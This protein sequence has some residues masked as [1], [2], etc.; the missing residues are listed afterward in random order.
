MMRI[1]ACVVILAMAR[2]ATEDPGFLR[3]SEQ[4]IG[5]EYAHLD[6]RTGRGRDRNL[7]IRDLTTP[8]AGQIPRYQYLPSQSK[9]FAPLSSIPPPPLCFRK[10]NI[11][12]PIKLPPSQICAGGERMRDFTQRIILAGIPDEMLEVARGELAPLLDFA[13]DNVIEGGVGKGSQGPQVTV[14]YMC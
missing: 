6:G 10:I 12:P 2:P 8:H 14:W 5:R 4:R 7:G 1:V 9:L 13:G 11:N 3:R